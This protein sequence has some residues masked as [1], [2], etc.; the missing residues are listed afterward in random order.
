MTCY[1]LMSLIHKHSDIIHH[2]N[3]TSYFQKKGDYYIIKAQLL[4]TEVIDFKIQRVKD[5]S[6]IKDIKNIQDLEKFLS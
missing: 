3:I 1:D 5:F 4:A 6:E 2:T